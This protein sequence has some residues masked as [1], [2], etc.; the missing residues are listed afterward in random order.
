M[1]FS[2]VKVDPINYKLRTL[3]TMTNTFFTNSF[4]IQKDAPKDVRE[5][6][7]V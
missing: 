6:T 2:N 7:D 1:G 4:R 5:Y 3:T